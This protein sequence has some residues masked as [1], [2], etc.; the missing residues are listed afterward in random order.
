MK[1]YNEKYPSCNKKVLDFL[2][3]QGL[4]GDI[5]I[6]QRVSGEEVPREEGVQ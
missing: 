4:Q 5:E 2:C 1:I 6:L 3:A